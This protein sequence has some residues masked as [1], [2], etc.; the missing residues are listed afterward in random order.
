MKISIG[1]SLKGINDSFANAFKGIGQLASDLMRNMAQNF[2][3][4]MPVVANTYGKAWESMVKTT[5]S[6]VQSMISMIG[7]LLSQL[8]QV[9]RQL[10]Q[11]MRS[12]ERVSQQA[13]RINVGNTLSKLR[14]T[15]YK[16]AATGAVI[17]PSMAEHL[18]KVGDNN[19]ETEI[20]SPL[21]TMKQAMSEVLA[22][23]NMSGNNG[24]I[25]VQIDGRE[26]FRAVR[27]QSDQYKKRTGSYAFG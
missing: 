2:A 18:I 11:T 16:G 6:A 22:N 4:G 12:M 3:S 9:P 21:S 13:S 1:S 8:N 20:V 19:R 25:V 7:K 23:M 24:D 27:E 15:S 14:G 5:Q 10:E 26:V 17:P